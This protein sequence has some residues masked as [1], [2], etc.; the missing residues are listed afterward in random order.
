[1]HAVVVVVAAAPA[2]EAELFSLHDETI[3]A[4]SKSAIIGSVLFI[5]EEGGIVNVVFL[6]PTATGTH[7]LIPLLAFPCEVVAP[8]RKIVVDTIY[9]N[10]HSIHLI[11]FLLI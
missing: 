6:E 4:A 11:S 1:M 9:I 10:I 8:I 2:L 7:A 5:F 3:D